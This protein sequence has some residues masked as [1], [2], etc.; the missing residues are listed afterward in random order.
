MKQ[1]LTDLI[2]QQNSLLNGSLIKQPVDE[3]VEK[4]MRNANIITHSIQGQLAG[5]IAYYCN[6]PQ[7]GLAFLTMLCVAPEHR[8][9]G[10]GS[11]LISYSICDIKSKGFKRYELEVN[12][13][14]LPAL[15]LY[16]NA[17]FEIT[18]VSEHTLKMIKSFNDE[19]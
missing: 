15:Q 12:E 19:G 2:Y 5:F 7:R 1:L 13:N 8:G 17:G 6:D 3:Y 10:I 16:K 11:N 18:T 9:K 4:I 14:N